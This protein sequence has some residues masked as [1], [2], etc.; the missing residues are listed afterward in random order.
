MKQKKHCPNSSS[1]IS[2]LLND[3]RLKR[4]MPV[5]RRQSLLRQTGSYGL[6]AEILRSFC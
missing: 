5:T 1:Y 4:S 2:G 6:Q 3:Y